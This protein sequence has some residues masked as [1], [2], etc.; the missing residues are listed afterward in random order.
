MDQSRRVFDLKV[1]RKSK[2]K[3]LLKKQKKNDNYWIWWFLI[4]CTVIVT[5]Y[6]KLLLSS[7]CT[8][9]ITRIFLVSPPFP[10]GGKPTETTTFQHFRAKFDQ[11]TFS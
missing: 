7:L 6:L 3:R 11:H 2:L 10:L 9:I 1:M 8:I 4:I 5:L